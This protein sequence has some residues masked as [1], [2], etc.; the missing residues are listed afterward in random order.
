[1]TE[2]IWFLEVPKSHSNKYQKIVILADN[3]DKTWDSNYDLDLQSELILAL[4]EVNTF[5]HKIL[6]SNNSYEINVKEIFFLRKDI[7]NFIRKRHPDQDKM[8]INTVEI[9]WEPRKPLLKELIERRFQFVLQ[10]DSLK[11]A[12]L[13]WSNHFNLDKPKDPIDVIFDVINLRP[14][15]LIVFVSRLFETAFNHG[16]DKVSQEDF[17]NT[18]EVYSSIANQNIIAEIKA[19]YPYVEDVFVE[20]QRYRTSAIQYPAFIKILTASG[21]PIPEQF[22]LIDTLFSKSYLLAFNKRSKTP[23]SDIDTLME[24]LKPKKWW[25]HWP[26]LP[27][28]SMYPHAKSY[29]LDSKRKRRF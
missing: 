24:E 16:R 13:V 5:I 21:V 4:F 14:R 27:K 20:L 15:D 1:M 12:Q 22:P 19:E 3:L 11:E 26:F 25:P 2:K 9:D 23:I 28:I 8:A 18:L 10:L 29:Y 7:Y 6:P 17:N